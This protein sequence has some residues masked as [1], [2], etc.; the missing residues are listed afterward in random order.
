MPTTAHRDRSWRR[1][2]PRAGDPLNVRTTD[3]GATI[4]AEGATA[5]FRLDEDGAG[6][7]ALKPGHVL[8]LGS[9]RTNPIAAIDPAAITSWRR[10][11]LL[12]DDVP[13]AQ[14]AAEINRYRRTPIKLAAGTGDMRI[15]GS[16]R[17]DGAGDF[18]A[19]VAA[20]LPATIDRSPSGQA[21]IVATDDGSK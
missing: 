16:F 19:A 4:L 15:S 2:Q 17:T 13:L 20:T 5:T 10:G 7:I 14:A 18:L 6:A 8:K 3:T 1:S 21:T 11:W 9:A 12:F